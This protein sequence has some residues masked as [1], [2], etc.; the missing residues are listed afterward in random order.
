MLSKSI[1]HCFSTACCKPITVAITG[2][3][4]NIGYASAFRI[5]AG[6]MFGECPVNLSLVDLPFAKQALKGVKEELLDC[7]FPLL[8]K[9]NIATNPQDGFKNA[10][11]ALL[12]GARP[13]GP[14]MERSDL[15]KA[16]GAI[17]I[18]QGKALN[19]F[20]NKNCK[21]IVIGNPCNTNCMIAKTYAPNLN[22]KNFSALTRLDQNRAIAQIRQK[23]GGVIGDYKKFA[24]WG[25]H[26]TTMFPDVSSATFKG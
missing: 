3:A 6:A 12:F 8:N 18:E 19:D 14:G 2:A 9:I 1:K 16:N 5:A 10:D 22:P 15:L 4:G 25:N 26:S 17:F 23:L 13:R 20:A 21:V 24:I 11:Y 7:S